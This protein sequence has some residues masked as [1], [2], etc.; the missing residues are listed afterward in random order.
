M[1]ILARLLNKTVTVK[2]YASVKN[3]SGDL[4]KTKSTISST[5][6]MRITRNTLLGSNQEYGVISKSTHEGFCNNGID[7]EVGDFV[8]DGSDEYHVTYV[9]K[10]PGGT[11]NHYQV[12]MIYDDG[13]I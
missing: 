9:D 8:V 12:Y 1:S 11:T 7:I 3:A 6:K 2:R 4:S 10:S 5:V 13:G